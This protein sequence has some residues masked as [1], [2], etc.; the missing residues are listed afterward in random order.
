MADL[1]QIENLHCDYLRDL[2]ITDG[3][4]DKDK[5]NEACD[6]KLVNSLFNDNTIK[7]LKSAIEQVE[8]YV[9]DAAETHATS[10][11]TDR[12]VLCDKKLD[13]CTKTLK[14]IINREISST[15]YMLKLLV[16]SEIN[17]DSGSKLGFKEYILPSLVKII[18]LSLD[19]KFK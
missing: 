11:N 6:K 2:C 18:I 4:N 15:A 3:N 13:N 12:W 7:D 8:K 5:C 1:Q 17:V 10:K 14:D 16:N 19:F 9:K